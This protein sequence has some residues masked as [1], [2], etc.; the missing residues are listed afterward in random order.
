M[1]IYIKTINIIDCYC[2]TSYSR[3]CSEEKSFC[4]KNSHHLK[5]KFKNITTL[6]Q[7][8]VKPR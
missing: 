2:L 1:Y 4:Y 6:S 5:N 8:T 3:V 7:A